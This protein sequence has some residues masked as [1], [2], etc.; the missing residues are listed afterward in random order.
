MLQQVCYLTVV[1]VLA[2]GLWPST[3]QEVE[4]H[5]LPADQQ[6][7]DEETPRQGSSL[8]L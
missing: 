8:L 6:A 5:P 2:S 1:L 4:A 7:S 3:T